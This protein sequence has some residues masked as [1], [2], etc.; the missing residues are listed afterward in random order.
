MTTTRRLSGMQQGQGHQ[1]TSLMLETY[2]AFKRKHLS[3]NKEIILKNSELHKTNADLQRQI[4]LMRGERLALKGT[5]FQLECENAALRDRLDRADERERQLIDERDRLRQGP[6]SSYDPEQVEAMRR[7]LAH[8]SAAL[9]AVHLM[10]PTGATPMP[11]PEARIPHA[12]PAEPL[13]PVASTS[14]TDPNADLNANISLSR[15]RSLAARA[16]RS[17]MAA[18]PDLSNISEGTSGEDEVDVA[19]ASGWGVKILPDMSAYAG[20]S[21]TAAFVAA[22]PVA[23]TSTALALP[24]SPP[25]PPSPAAATPPLSTLSRPARAPRAPPKAPS[26]T[27][28]DS[29]TPPPTAS[30]SSGSSSSSSSSSRPKRRVSG[31]LRPGLASAGSSEFGMAEEDDGEV[32]QPAQDR[33]GEVEI[34]SPSIPVTVEVRST[35]R[36]KRRASSLIAPPMLATSSSSRSTRGGRT[37]EP[38][39]ELEPASPAI[40]VEE[41][42]EDERRRTA[43]REIQPAPP[44]EPVVVPS[45]AGKLKGKGKAQPSAPSSAPRAGG[46]VDDDLSHSLS[47]SRGAALLQAKKDAVRTQRAAATAPPVVDEVEN[48]EDAPEEDTSASSLV[49]EETVLGPKSRTTKARR[50]EELEP[51][52]EEGAGAV[53]RS[54]SQESTEEGAGGRRARKS[55]NYALPKLNTKMRRPEDYK[56]VS[57]P[58]S[59]SSC[60]A[61]PRKS[62]KAPSSSSSSTS[63]HTTAPPIPPLDA[64]AA[65]PPSLAGKKPRVPPPPPVDSPVVE[66]SSTSSDDDD[67]EWNERQFL[68]RASSSSSSART[69]AADERRK[70]RASAAPRSGPGAGGAGAGLRRHSVAV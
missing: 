59:S 55:V 11:S 35:A 48:D 70:A 38:E 49:A 68:K 33:D 47:S 61:K 17:S 1:S 2:E 32:E 8:A 37:P 51:L 69:A 44:V 3:Q 27:S 63:S 54:E 31:M 66:D 45:T 30:G 52:D 21:T 57:K 40:R 41:D 23:S 36:G 14:S 25:S 42:E 39:L 43:L 7:A 60:G 20:P 53:A 16:A 29:L 13:A 15:R 50:V 22:P 19:P 56:P 10:L 65:R 46:D 9:Q 12:P 62:S 64:P 34:E 67:A 6:A 28:H 58:A 5:Q 18:P 26:A 4:S 24:V